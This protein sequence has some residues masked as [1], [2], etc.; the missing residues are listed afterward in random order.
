MDGLV[1]L[2]NRVYD[3]ATRQFLSPDPLPGLP[4]APAAAHPYA[5]ADDDPVGRFDPL[6]LQGQPLSIDQYNQFREQAYGWQTENLVTVGLV[7]AGVAMM[8]IPGIGLGGM[9]LIGAGLG[10]V[11]GAAPGIIHGIETGEWDWG[12]IGGGALKGAVI[13]GVSAFGGG[14]LGAA[15]RG[16]GPLAGMLT[17]ATRASTAARGA[18]AGGGLGFGSGVLG[19]AYDLT[20]LPGSD[21]QFDPE[22]VVVNTVL[23]AGTGGAGGALSFRPPPPEPPPNRVIVDTN[24]VFNRPGVE[25]NLQPGEV[26]V[27]TEM[28]RA[29]LSSLANRPVNPRKMPRY[30]DELDTIP[31][32]MDVDTRIDIRGQLA[33]ISPNQRGMFGDGT[34]GATAVNTGHPVITADKKFARVLTEM[35]VEVRR[36]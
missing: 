4:G 25:A 3:P 27:V 23:G 13:G 1:W 28:T 17:G 20:P 10:A 26:P 22:G 11:G 14:A 31:D 19:E 7:A 30:A 2:R 33:E 32:V 6:G 21:G 29:E 34:I 16:G 8:F 15:A 35:G 24:A 12:A 5:Y 9:A 18:L 36:P